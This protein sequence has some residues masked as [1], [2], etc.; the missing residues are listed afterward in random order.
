MDIGRDHLR[1]AT[2]QHLQLQPH[3]F[4]ACI[5]ED[6]FSKSSLAWTTVRGPLAVDGLKVVFCCAG[7]VIAALLEAGFTVLGGIF[8]SSTGLKLTVGSG[9][10]E[11][12]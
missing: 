7:L 4:V 2:C 12:C 3:F 1:P 11:C 8:G 6:L 10:L 5:T 9:L